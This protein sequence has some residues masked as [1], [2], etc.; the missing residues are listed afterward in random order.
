VEG[1]YREISF[2]G[3]ILAKAIKT[4]AYEAENKAG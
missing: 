1:I 4:M 2:D 3:N